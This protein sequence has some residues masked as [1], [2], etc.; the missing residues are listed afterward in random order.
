MTDQEMDKLNKIKQQK[1]DYYYRNRDVI[2]Q[3]QKIY[4]CTPCGKANF[5]RA[6]E[7]YF[8]SKI[9]KANGGCETDAQKRAKSVYYRKQRLLLQ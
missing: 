1:R 6:K 4:Q 3:K 8:N 9:K 2:R 7:Q 5:R